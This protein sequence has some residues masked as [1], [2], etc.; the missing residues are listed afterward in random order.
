MSLQTW[1][2]ALYS[3]IADATQISNTVTETIMVPDTAIPARYWYPGRTVHVLMTGML[4]NVVTT[5]G[6]LT[7]RARYG[8]VAGTPLAASAALA[9]NTTAQTNSQVW[10]EFLL[11]CR[12]TGWSA[13]SGTMWTSGHAA[14]GNSRSTQGLKDLIPASGNAVVS[15]LD[16][17]SAGTLSFT[18]QFS[19]ATN[20]TNLIINQF[21]LKA[22]N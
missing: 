21:V 3:S 2:E 22:L 12:L 17:T 20:P 5:P 13:T 7:L 8:G 19:V 6:T 9:L 10:I 15:S 18:A 11:V 4:S 1:E 14:L 16:L